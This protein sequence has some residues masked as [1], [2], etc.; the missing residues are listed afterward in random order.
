MAHATHRLSP[1]SSLN[2]RLESYKEEEK[3]NGAF[4]QRNPCPQ[5][6]HQPEHGTCDLWRAERHWTPTQSHI[7]P[8]ILAYDGLFV[9][10]CSSKLVNLFHLQNF[11]RP[12][13]MNLVGT[14][15]WG[16]DAFAEGRKLRVINTLLPPPRNLWR[17]VIFTR[18][19]LIRMPLEEKA[20]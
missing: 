11:V 10:T 17:V 7:S 4:C 12:Y 14:P 20:V 5:P 6:P 15:H 13:G 2:S 8:S 3:R 9:R 18:G 16:P 19:L 1:S